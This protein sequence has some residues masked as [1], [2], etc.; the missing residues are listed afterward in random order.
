MM[1]TRSHL[2]L[3][4]LARVMAMLVAALALLSTL[5]PAHAASLSAT[6]EKS[7]RAV[8]EGQL[9]ALAKDDAGKAFSYAAPNV[10]RRLGSSAAFIAMLRNSYPMIY[11][12]ASVAFLKPEGQNNHAIQR[13]QILDAD[14]DAWLAIYSLERQKNK[15]W[16]ITGCAVMENKGRMA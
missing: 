1:K 6:D 4:R 9:A 7:V 16:R 10:R 11:R 15:T 13:V 2:F 8:I 3:A 5:A 12:P 14:G